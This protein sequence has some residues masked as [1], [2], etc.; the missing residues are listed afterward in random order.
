ML[1]DPFNTFC[2]GMLVGLILIFI[3]LKVD[4]REKRAIEVGFSQYNVKTGNYEYINKEYQYVITG[5][6]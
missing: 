5:K 6:K 1:K 4:N 2:L 3:F